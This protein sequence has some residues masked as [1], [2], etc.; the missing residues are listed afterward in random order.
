MASICLKRL[1]LSCG[2]AFNTSKGTTV[3]PSAAWTMNSSSLRP[4]SAKR[5]ATCLTCAIP[6]RGMSSVAQAP[7]VAFK[8]EAMPPS[9]TIKD[10]CGW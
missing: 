10:S 4:Y 7:S 5:S 6:V 8:K 2:L 9:G 3:S 1:N